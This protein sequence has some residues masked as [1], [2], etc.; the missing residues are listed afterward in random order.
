[1]PEDIVKTSNLADMAPSTPRHL[2]FRHT[3]VDHG[4]V[5]KIAMPLLHQAL[6]TRL[7]SPPGEGRFP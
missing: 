3:T 1:M 6:V 5:T 4:S 7:A 2:E